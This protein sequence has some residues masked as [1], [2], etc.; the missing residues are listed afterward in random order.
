MTG[1][2]G[3]NRDTFEHNVD[4]C[5]QWVKIGQPHR[6]LQYEMKKKW[7]LIKMERV[8]RKTERERV[9]GTKRVNE[10][11][12]EGGGLLSKCSNFEAKKRKKLI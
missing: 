1:R 4:V 2:Q 3:L 5:S 8:E 11:E 6:R 7:T 12:R 9:R 10:Y